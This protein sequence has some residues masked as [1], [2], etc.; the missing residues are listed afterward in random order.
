M[1]GHVTP[2]KIF[3]TGTTNQ[4]TS[5][6]SSIDIPEDG[7]ILGIM[8]H[9]SANGMNLADD[10]VYAELSFLSTHQIE[11]NDARGSILEVMVQFGMLSS[12]AG[13]ASQM[14]TLSFIP[15]SGIPVNAGER[16]HLHTFASNGPVPKGTFMIYLSS[17]GAR[18]S[19]RR[20]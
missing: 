15:G 4:F 7:E 12:G 3:G 1:T 10:K 11:S 16:I 17:G 6:V 20:R 19:S 13:P 14:I 8:G 18:R 9:I 5:D 2:I